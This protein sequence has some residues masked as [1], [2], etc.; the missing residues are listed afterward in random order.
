MVDFEATAS[1][2][3]PAAPAVTCTPATGSLF[4]VGETE[5]SCRAEDALGHLVTGTFLVRVAAAPPDLSAPVL[6]AAPTRCRR[7]TR[8]VGTTT[9]VTLT[10][11]G[12]TSAPECRPG[13]LHD[14]SRGHHHRA[15]TATC[16]DKAGNTATSPAETVRIDLVAPTLS[17]RVPASLLL[18]AAAKAGRARP[19][20]AAR[21]WP[22]H[23]ARGHHRGDRDPRGQVQGDRQGRQHHGV[24][25]EL[26]R[27]RPG[28][29]VRHPPSR[30]SSRP[31][32]TLTTRSGSPVRGP[33]S[34][35]VGGARRDQGRTRR[36]DRPE[37][38]CR[39]A[40]HRTLQLELRRS[41]YA[42]PLALPKS[43]A[44]GKRK[45]YTLKVQ[46]RTAPG[47][48][49]TAPGKRNKVRLHLI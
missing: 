21:G 16:T 25:P 39:F 38:R 11:T 20:P 49:T 17:P 37:D 34:I 33:L 35:G 1:D 7:R 15:V 48:W 29:V 14:E 41:T 43:L 40:A 18:G 2:N 13:A 36:P 44:A 31:S 22:P 42:C 6:A 32:E 28:D 45:P 24:Q 8:R 23:R 12:R 19:T 46:L 30:D 9:P 26:H 5:V 27:A 47:T 4:P 10:W 3:D